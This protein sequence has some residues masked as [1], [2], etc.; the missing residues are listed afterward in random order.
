MVKK[1]TKKV[2]KKLKDTHESMD[3]TGTLELRRI[4]LGKE[5]GLAARIKALEALKDIGVSIDESASGGLSSLKAV[6]GLMQESL[7][8]LTNSDKEFPSAISNRILELS[9]DSKAVFVHRL[10]K[11]AGEKSLSLLTKLLGK[12]EELDLII[13]ESLAYLATQGSANLLLQMAT[14]AQ[15]KPL[16]KA[17]KRSLYR[18]KEKGIITEDRGTEESRLS[19]LRPPARVFE[20]YLSYIDYLGYR[21]VW[22]TQPRLTKGLYFFQVIINDTEGI[23]DF[24]GTEITKKM[25]REY[26]TGFKEKSPMPIVEAE[27]SYC[28][29]LIQEGYTMATKRGHPVPTG[30]LKWKDI[31]GKPSGEVQRPLIY[32][33]YEEDTIKADEALLTSS[34]TLFELPE[35]GNWVIRPDEIE[36]YAEKINEASKSKLVLTPIQKQERISQIYNDAADELFNEE[37]RLLY[38]RRLEESAYIIYKLGKEKDARICL[39][40]AL[41]LM[42]E[43]IPSSH[44]PFL[45]ELVKRSLSSAIWEEEQKAR[46]NPSFII[47]P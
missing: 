31:V 38:K 34:G 9:N 46:E 33:C 3:R 16:K 22:L 44:H 41:A 17:I 25:Y 47:K 18:L 32:S 28:Q 4:A 14:E 35:F 26:L 11:D 37:R 21:L 42:S 40:A 36:Q 12:N 20:G 30:Y 10:I 7:D 29:F 24:H 27:P 19:V 39:A 23:K 15:S 1:S 13:A 6:Y 45:L 5:H 2:Q 43:G 8:S